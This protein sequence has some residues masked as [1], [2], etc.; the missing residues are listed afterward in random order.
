MKEEQKRNLLLVRYPED[1][2]VV[3][4]HLHSLSLLQEEKE[5]KWKNGCGNDNV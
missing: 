3:L 2:H 4:S 5:R 1:R